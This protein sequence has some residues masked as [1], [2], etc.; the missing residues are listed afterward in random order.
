MLYIFIG[1]AVQKSHV[2]TNKDKNVAEAKKG[3]SCIQ[4]AIWTHIWLIVNLINTS[5]NNSSA[6]A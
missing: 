6:R 2:A 1:L 4:K 5:W 3:A